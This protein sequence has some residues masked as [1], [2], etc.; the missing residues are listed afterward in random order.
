M[1]LWTPSEPVAELLLRATVVYLALLLM[2]R[3]SGKRTVAQ[4]TPFDL[5]VVMLISEATQSALIA[6]DSSVSGGLIVAATLLALNYGLGFV[7]ARNRT[8]DRLVEGKPVLVARDGAIYRDALKK[9]S[10]SEA[11]FREAMRKH[12]ILHEEQIRFAFLETDG[13][14]TIIDRESAAKP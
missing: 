3:V 8:L 5:V 12:G 4:F 14:I 10:I 9:E 1:D 13:R 7:T 6:D 2:V 11:D